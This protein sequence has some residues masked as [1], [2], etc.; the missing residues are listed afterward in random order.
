[1]ALPTTARSTSVV[2]RTALSLTSPRAHAPLFSRTELN[3]P[4]LALGRPARQDVA[5]GG[6]FRFLTA[7]LTF[8]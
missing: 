3:L 4:Y 1:V 2:S 8:S 5:G 6:G 7:T